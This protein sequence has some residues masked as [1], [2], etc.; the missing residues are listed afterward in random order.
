MGTSAMNT[1]AIDFEWTWCTD[2]YELFA[3][4][5]NGRPVGIVAKSPHFRHYSPMENR[6]L[7]VR[8]IDCPANPDG[9]LSFCNRFGIPMGKGVANIPWRGKRVHEVSLDTLLSERKAMKRTFRLFKI[10]NRLNLINF[11]NANDSPLAL[12]RAHLR[13]EPTGRLSMALM[14]PDLLR[15]MWLQLALYTCSGLELFRCQ[16][17]SDPFFVG[18]GTKRRSTAQYCSRACKQAAFNSSR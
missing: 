5:A 18:P 16:R 9:M 2:G 15:A 1:N 17:C 11:W 3:K 10:G 8:F 7:F 6:E 13:E 14:P 12:L 4:T